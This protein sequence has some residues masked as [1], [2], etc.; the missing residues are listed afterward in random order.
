MRKFFL[1]VSISL[2]LTVSVFAGGL[3]P[4][5]GFAGCENGLYYPENGECVVGLAQS[6]SD[7]KQGPV[8]SETTLI[9]AILS[10]RDMIF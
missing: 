1:T 2:A 3:V 8:F 4:I 7:G 6:N 10:F 5:S 9:G